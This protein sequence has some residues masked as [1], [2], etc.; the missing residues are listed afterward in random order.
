MDGGETGKKWVEDITVLQL[1]SSLS[2]AKLR[3]R[4]TVPLYQGGNIEISQNR[5]ID[6]TEANI[7]D[8]FFTVDDED[9]GCQT[10]HLLRMWRNWQTR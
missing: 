4:T 8:N 6:L 5:R 9:F 10:R 7:A 3:P 1:G 2:A